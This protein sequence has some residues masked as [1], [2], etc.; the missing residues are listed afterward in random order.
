MHVPPQCR[1]VKGHILVLARGTPQP[2][3][4]LDGSTVPWDMAA[5]RWEQCSAPI[6]L[7][8]RPPCC[9][10]VLSQVFNFEKL[11]EKKTWIAAQEFCRELGAQ[12]LSL[13]SYEEEHFVANTLNKIFG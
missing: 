13:G 12:L 2:W 4:G 10:F 3:L 6:L 11:Q 8:K 7:V 9:E 5:C 1:G